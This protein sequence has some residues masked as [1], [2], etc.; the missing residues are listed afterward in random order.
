MWRSQ[1]LLFCLKRPPVELPV[2][3]CQRRV[4]VVLYIEIVSKE[5]YHEVRHD[6]PGE[7][8]HQI[9]AAFV[10]SK[11]LFCR[12]STPKRMG[13][14]ACPKREWIQTFPKSMDFLGFFWC[15]SGAFAHCSSYIWRGFIAKSN[16]KQSDLSR[17]ASSTGRATATFRLGAR[18][19][20]LYA[21]K[22]G[23]QVGKQIVTNIHE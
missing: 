17:E 3:I 23:R 6:Q 5:W 13:H 7:F 22:A 8:Y 2:R 9:L 1:L 4:R 14:L 12:R 10:G 21:S 16:G 15:F 11:H 18:Y 19:P 20:R